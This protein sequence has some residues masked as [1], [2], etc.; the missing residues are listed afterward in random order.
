MWP[1]QN[2]GTGPLLELPSHSSH[3]LTSATPVP[4][5][6]ASSPQRLRGLCTCMWK[7]LWWPTC[8]GSWG[9]NWTH[10]AGSRV[11][12]G[13]G[14]ASRQLVL[15]RERLM[16]TV[17]S[18]SADDNWFTESGS[19]WH[20]I[21]KQARPKFIHPSCLSPHTA[22]CV[23]LLSVT[24]SVSRASLLRSLHTSSERRVE[25]GKTYPVVQ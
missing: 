8:C 21:Q 7:S 20:K 18:V 22:G 14:M 12:S 25:T 5:Q 6:P 13:S 1:R 19:G 11:T 16:I 10:S 2:Q 9:C 23:T 24:L 4:R 15:G 3:A 17:G